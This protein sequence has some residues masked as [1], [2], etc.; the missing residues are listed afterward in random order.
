MHH[1]DA[2]AFVTGPECTVAA[3]A[4][5]AE[6][7]RASHH[8]ELFCY[9]N[10]SPEATLDLADAWGDALAAEPMAAEQAPMPEAVLLPVQSAA[11]PLRLSCTCANPDE[12]NCGIELHMQLGSSPS[13]HEEALLLTL[14][15]IASRDAF[16]ELRTVRQLGY[17]VACGF[18]SISRLTLTLTLT[19]TRCASSAT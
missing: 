6:A 9:G 11:A 5:H 17:V 15:Q 4:A 14:A 12:A 1:R 7:V 18:R 8:L 2:L 16:H 19:L 13:L 10:L 3:L